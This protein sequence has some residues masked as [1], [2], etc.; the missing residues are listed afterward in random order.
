MEVI[1][2][3]IIQLRAVLLVACAAG[4]IIFL[5]GGLMST[6]DLERVSFRLERTAVVRRAATYFTRALF[7]LALGGGVY[8]LTS[9]SDAS[10]IVTTSSN[11]AVATMKI[12]S[13]PF[14]L[15]I[16]PLPTAD[17][18]Q[19][20]AVAQSVAGATSNPDP[21]S[22]PT[23]SLD[24]SLLVAVTA[25]PMPGIDSPAPT[26][27]P[28]PLSAVD[29]LPTVPPADTP[30]VFAIPTATNAP[31]SESIAALP[32]LQGTS[33]ATPELTILFD[34]A[35]APPVADAVCGTVAR[36]TRPATGETVSGEYDIVGS[37]VFAGGRYRLEVLPAGESVWRSL[38]ESN[39]S[40]T[41]QM[42]LPAR[43]QSALFVN[44]T[45][46]ARLLVFGSNGDE[47]ARCTTSFNIQN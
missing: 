36:L 24:E 25:T 10:T 3:N 47:V 18:Q 15:L 9:R 37:A 11:G 46:F 12:T 44:G 27:T 22:M 23:P 26:T 8:W 4:V 19:A 32:V 6:R 45:Y 13:T 1:A 7:F 21:M 17:L 20:Q 43:F 41:E 28:E 14:S 16:T 38:W 35:A 39:A 30:T 31:T 40:V 29:M 42:L 33:E 2:Q 34:T 5:F